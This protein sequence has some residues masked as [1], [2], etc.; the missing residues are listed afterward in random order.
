MS[1]GRIDVTRAR[2]EALLGGE[3]KLEQ[4]LIRSL[5]DPELACRVKL[6][7]RIG[8]ELAHLNRQIDEL[9]KQRVALL[10]IRARALQ[11]EG[12]TDDAR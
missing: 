1:P 11:T 10:R 2:L 5:A 12:G 3:D 8:E 7:Q 9:R 4:L 6:R